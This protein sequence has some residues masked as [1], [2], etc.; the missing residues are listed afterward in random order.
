MGQSNTKFDPLQQELSN[1]LRVFDEGEQGIDMTEY[2]EYI[3]HPKPMQIPPSDI[4]DLII[5]TFKKERQRSPIK[6]PDTCG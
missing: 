2:Q 1:K 6:W 5:R 3:D 4:Y